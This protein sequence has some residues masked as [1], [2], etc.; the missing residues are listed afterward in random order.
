MNKINNLYPCPCCHHYIFTE[1][2]C[3]EICPICGWED[4][5]VQFEDPDYSGGANEESLN[6]YKLHFKNHINKNNKL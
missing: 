3:F 6:E 4:D 2:H 5:A 1:L